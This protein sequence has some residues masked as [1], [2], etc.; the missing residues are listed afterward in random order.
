[1]DKNLIWHKASYAFDKVCEVSG[2]G[3]WVMG[4]IAKPIS[5]ACET[6]YSMKNS[7]SRECR[8]ACNNT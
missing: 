5:F 3:Y 2:L 1:M 4:R 8:E 7:M 6:L